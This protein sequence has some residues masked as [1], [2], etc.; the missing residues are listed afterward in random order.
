MMSA[1]LRIM[2]VAVALFSGVSAV[3]ARPMLDTAS[4]PTDEFNNNQNGG[5]AYWDKVVRE[6]N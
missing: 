1:T 2:L 4:S 3:A 6:G 5:K